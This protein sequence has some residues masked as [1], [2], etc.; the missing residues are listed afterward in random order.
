MSPFHFILGP[1]SLSSARVLAKI[2]RAHLEAV[3]GRRSFLADRFSQGSHESSAVIFFKTSSNAGKLSERCNS[4]RNL[5]IR[6]N[7]PIHA[8]T[9]YQVVEDVIRKQPLDSLDQVTFGDHLW[10]NPR[11]FT[12]FTVC[13]FHDIVPGYLVGQQLNLGETALLAKAS[14]LGWMILIL[15]REDSQLP[16]SVF[17]KTLDDLSCKFARIKFGEP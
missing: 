4:W 16:S 8:S 5:G 6:S 14:T 9:Q 2:V 7:H 15:C 11:S 3:Q 10:T 12:G 13:C 17:S 1:T